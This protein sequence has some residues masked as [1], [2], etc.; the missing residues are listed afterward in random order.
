MNFDL[1]FGGGT[2]LLMVFFLVA[3][4]YTG[5][6][7]MTSWEKLKKKGFRKGTEETDDFLEEN[8]RILDIVA[9]RMECE[10]SVFLNGNKKEIPTVEELRDSSEIASLSRYAHFGGIYITVEQIPQDGSDPD[11]GDPNVFKTDM[12][13]AA[14]SREE[15]LEDKYSRY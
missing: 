1:I 4:L 2:I 14:E 11:D 9:E 10:A 5:I 7:N 3:I 8:S 12:A 15:R 6:D 13:K